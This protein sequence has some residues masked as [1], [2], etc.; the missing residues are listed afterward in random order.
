MATILITHGIPLQGWTLPQGHTTWHPKEGGRFSREELLGLLP[1]ADAVLACGDFGADRIQAG[2]KLKLIVCYGAG[3]ER[4]DLQEATRRGIP[5]V[6]IPQAVVHPTAE[7]ALALIMSLARRIPM[8][9][10]EMRGPQPES[11][12]G[13]GK[14]MGVSLHGSTLGIV[15]MGNIGS[16]VAEVARAL[17]MGILYHARGPKPEQDAAGARFC[18][19][20][21]LMAEADFVSLHCPLTPETR[22]LIT[23]EL[24]FSMKPTAF[25]VNTARGPVVDEDALLEA[26]GQSRIAGAGLDV[27]VGEPRINPLFRSLPNVIMTPHVGSNTL[28]ARREMAETA[29]LVIW[30]ALLEGKR[31]HHLL[32]PQVWEKEGPFRG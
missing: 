27:F 1:E 9:D 10:R 5:V 29:S 15:G 21:E 23:R 8:L 17:G 32:N 14:A 31:P 24:L 30:E 25:L 11:A 13:M 20:A 4:V 28:Q 26:L 16:R 12:F 7:L 19:L 6:N 22:G 3:Y 2:E 18:S